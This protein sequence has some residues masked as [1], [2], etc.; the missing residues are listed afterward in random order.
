MERHLNLL[1]LSLVLAF[2]IPTS[3][4]IGQSNLAGPYRLKIDI[5]EQRNSPIR[6]VFDSLRSND[7]GVIPIAPDGYYAKPPD[8]V[9]LRLENVSGAAVIAYALVSRAQG[10]HN[11]QVNPLTKPLL[12]GKQFLRGFGISGSEEIEYSLDYVLFADGRSW[13]EDRFV[14]SRQIALYFEGHNAAIE[15]LRILSASYSDPDDFIA[16]ASS[17]GGYL[18]SD[19]VGEPNP[20]KFAIQY[21]LGWVHITDLLRSNPVRQKESRELADR[22]EAR[23]PQR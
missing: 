7:C 23:I 16:R 9:M 22:L 20:V 18:S 14:R 6:L 21:R 11:V 1:F 5:L 12:P 17:F 10:F 4:V 8:N 13:G 2:L 19:P 15:Q 3:S